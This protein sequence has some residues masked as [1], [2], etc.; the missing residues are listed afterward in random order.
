MLRKFI[1]GSVDKFVMG[2]L[3]LEKAACF[4]H[5]SDDLISFGA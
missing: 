4:R 2:V 5:R 1:A 3:G